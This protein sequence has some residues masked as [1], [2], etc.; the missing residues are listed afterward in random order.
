[1]RADPN[2]TRPKLDKRNNYKS[3]N[4]IPTKKIVAYSHRSIGDEIT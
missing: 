4:F 3:Y 2:W 1:M